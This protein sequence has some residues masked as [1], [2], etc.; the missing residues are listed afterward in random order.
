MMIS[1][2]QLPVGATARVVRVHG[3][4]ALRRRMLDVGLTRGAEVHVRKVAPLGDPIEI[5]LRHYT[6]SIRREDAAIVEIES[7]SSLS[8][9][10]DTKH[11]GRKEQD[12]H[13]NGTGGKSQRRKDNAV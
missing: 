6:L 2:Q 5:S 10:N 13:S 9:H 1:L 4:G 7:D 8:G 12:G 3:T 11:S